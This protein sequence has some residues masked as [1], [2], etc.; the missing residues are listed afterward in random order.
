M[1]AMEPGGIGITSGNRQLG[2][3]TP[4]GRRAERKSRLSAS[5]HSNHTVL[6][7]L[8]GREQER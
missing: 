6:C 2:A 8:A 5:I 3:G 7:E 1:P 4:I